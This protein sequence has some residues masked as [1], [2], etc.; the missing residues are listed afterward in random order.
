M[1]RGDAVILLLGLVGGLVIAARATDP[2]AVFIGLWALGITAAYS[3]ISYKVPWIALNMLVPLAILG[4]VAVR[5]FLELVRST[6]L[7]AFGAVGLAGGLAFGAWQSLDLNFRRYD[8][9]FAS[10][11]VF[12]HTTRQALD[13]LRETQRVATAAGTGTETGIVYASPDYWPLPWYYRAY[14]R[15]GFFGSIVDTSEAMI[16]V[17]V[18]QEADL[19][20]RFGDRY[21][22]RG[23]YNLRPGVDLVLY[24]RSDLAGL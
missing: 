22:R 24:V 23:V 12:V 3:L 1:A 2:L 5:E 7:R 18:N 9:E 8:D 17:N 11:Y 20:A 6:R 13:L 4:G 10:P 15:A 16:V 19:T 21:Q 14:P